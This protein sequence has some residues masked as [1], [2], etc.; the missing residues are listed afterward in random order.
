MASW[1]VSS[2]AVRLHL[3]VTINLLLLSLDMCFYQVI[4]KQL[5]YYYHYHYF[6]FFILVS[7]APITARSPKVWPPLINSHSF[8]QTLTNQKLRTVSSWLLIGLNLPK[9]MWIN[10]KRS[11]FWALCCNKLNYYLSFFLNFLFTSL[12]DGHLWYWPYASTAKRC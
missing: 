5:F 11:H 3:F 8:M 12:L 10:Q 7:L 9:K 6:F 1:E 4:N 2:V